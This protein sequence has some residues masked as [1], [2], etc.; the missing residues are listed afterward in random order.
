[1]IAAKTTFIGAP[2]SCII[3]D[4]IVVATFVLTSAPIKF[5]PADIKIAF[6][7]ESA[8]VVTELAIALAV[9]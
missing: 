7:G 2:P 1:M 6:C 8:L 4:P 5:N 9:S 3:P